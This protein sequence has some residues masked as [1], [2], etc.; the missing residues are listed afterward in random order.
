MNEVRLSGLAVLFIGVALL[1]FTFICA[2]QFL[3]GVLEI[4]ASEDLMKLF[5]EALSPLISYAVRTLYLG[6]MGW[7]GS[8]LTRRGVQ[9][10]TATEKAEKPSEKNRAMEEQGV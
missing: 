3:M 5:G 4:A 2:Y 7:I 8:I 9:I 6:I 10:L 1:I